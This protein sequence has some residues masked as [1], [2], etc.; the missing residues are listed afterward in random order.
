MIA[1][2]LWELSLLGLAYGIAAWAVRGG[3]RG[4]AARTSGNGTASATSEVAGG[5]E[6]GAEFA[7][8][9]LILKLLIGAAL[10]QTAA[11][12]GV[13]SGPAFYWA[14]LGCALAGGGLWYLLARQGHLAELWG[15]AGNGRPRLG[16]ARA[17]G[18]GR[19]LCASQ[20]SLPAVFVAVAVVLV[21]P[22][23]GSSIT[24][25]LE[26]DSIVQSH[27]LLRAAAGT[28]H[29]FDFNKNYVALWQAAY[30]PGLVLG[31]SIAQ[32]ALS[33]VQAAL[34]FALVAYLLARVL[35]L[36]TLVAGLLAVTAL[37][38]G[39]LW[40]NYITGVGTLKNDT[41]A[42]AGTLLLVLAAVRF[43]RA[44]QLDFSLAIVL[45]GG[46][47]FASTKS[48][49]PVQVILV[50]G[51]LAV[52]FHR[53][54]LALN[55][56]SG[57]LLAAVV[58][59]FMTTCGLYYLRNWYEFGNPFYPVPIKLGPIA[60]PGTLELNGLSI[61]D[62]RT[63]PE[64]W[65][66]FFGLGAHRTSKT[67]AAFVVL[68]LLF[69][70]MPFVLLWW[71]IKDQRMGAGQTSTMPTRTI[72]WLLWLI[73]L[74][75]WS[76]YLYTPWSS[77]SPDNPTVFLQG[78]NSF[79]YA[80]ANTQLLLTLGVLVLLALGRGGERAWAAAVTVMVA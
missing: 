19:G 20:L 31:N 4:G 6:R 72:I 24:L 80:I 68:V 55:G 78:H 16:P 49:G 58:L 64:I 30:L 29:P 7:T 17:R 46:L 39:H 76:L 51:L 50:L 57:L 1:Y 11:F 73:T 43:V 66:M 3:V 33:S 45:S 25:V 44:G 15:F 8:N 35:G 9:G 60:L 21:S 53:Q 34:L 41:I 10:P 32:L 61:M 14:T 48:A 5:A 59:A 27:W 75:L 22:A 65:R 71:R 67:A 69:A 63:N 13:V 70:A 62:N 79:R 37:L 40:G 54:L 23:L 2:L 38:S 77:G 12:L 52:F 42:A 28:G 18:W 74:G 47:V 56:R 36:T 26:G